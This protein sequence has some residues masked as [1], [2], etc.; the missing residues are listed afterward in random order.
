VAQKP[1]SNSDAV[2]PLFGFGRAQIDDETEYRQRTAPL[3]AKPLPTKP[4]TAAIDLTGKP[5]V[6]L[7]IG[8]G[9]A[10]KT[11]LARWMGWRMTEMGR[12][13]MIAA[14]DP[15]NRS[16]ATWFAGV[17]QPE[18]S[19]PGYTARWLRSAL[20]HMMAEK[21]SGIF[22]FGGGDVSLRTVIDM[23]PSLA[24]DMTG[25]GVEPVACYCIGPSQ[26]DLTS[27]GSLEESGFRPRS[28]L[29]V[30]N[31]GKV[32]S[33]LSREEAFARVL[34]HSDFRAAVGRGALPIW[35]PRLEPDVMDQ[36]EGKHITFGQARDGQVPEGKTFSP[37]GGLDR[38]MVARWLERME[39][40]F[41]PVATWLA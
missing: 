23:A 6:W 13:A 39:E 26:D 22:D 38:S 14:L 16:L 28:T 30:L 37:I 4:A 29:L 18:L 1:A 15:T 33:M 36:I 24:D 25:A 21:T 17:E 32:D 10:G 35:M 3:S 2:V 11:V 7:L 19:D 8:R 34:R 27:L 41:Q 12:E 5:K 9:G 20:S 40:A 31:E